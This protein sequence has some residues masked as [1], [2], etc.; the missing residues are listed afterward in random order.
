MGQKSANLHIIC[1]GCQWMLVDSVGPHRA[2]HIPS[3]YKN[4]FEGLRF[5]ARCKSKQERRQCN[6]QSCSV[7]VKSRSLFFNEIHLLLL[8]L[9]LLLN[10]GVPDSKDG[11]RGERGGSAPGPHQFC[12]W[13]AWTPAGLASCCAASS[14]SPALRVRQSRPVPAVPPQGQSR[15]RLYCPCLPMPHIALLYPT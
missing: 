4:R 9:L 15:P 8:R 3:W 2:L 13:D 7:V 1:V 12:S 5:P 6:F 10:P 14:T 11:G